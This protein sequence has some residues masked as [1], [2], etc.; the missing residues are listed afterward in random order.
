MSPEQA[1]Q[2][3]SE[4]RTQVK[5]SPM[6]ATDLISGETRLN[7]VRVE[8]QK[9]ADEFWANNWKLLNS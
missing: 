5:N 8:L 9:K 4:L 2:V 3:M 1:K 6:Y 7:V